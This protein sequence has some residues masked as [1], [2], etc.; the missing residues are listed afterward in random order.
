MV[1]VAENDRGEI[2]LQAPEKIGARNLATGVSVTV[3]VPGPNVT[4]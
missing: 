3:K 4:A 2:S 1:P